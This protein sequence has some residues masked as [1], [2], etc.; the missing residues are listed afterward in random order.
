MN[1]IP[2]TA[3]RVA[4]FLF[5]LLILCQVL[6]PQAPAAWNIRLTALTVFLFL[7]ASVAASWHRSGPRFALSLAGFAFLV[8]LGS[9]ILGVH[10]GFPFSTY[11]YTDALQPQLFEVPILIPLAWAMMAYPAWRIGE[12]IGNRPLTRAIAAAGALAAWDVALDP[13]MVGQGLWIWP[14]GGAYEGIPLV[15]FLGWFTV[16][17]VLFGWWALIVRPPTRPSRLAAADLLG[18]ALYLWTWIG[19]T[20]AHSLFFA[21]WSVAVAS[22]VAMGAFALPALVR[23]RRGSASA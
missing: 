18:P 13:Q 12:L 9:E 14:N 15:N 8:G 1:R 6:Y 23:L 16:G 3:A 2:S 20:V 10:T 21:G 19:E 4:C 11:W 17:L 7:G 22:F 5:A